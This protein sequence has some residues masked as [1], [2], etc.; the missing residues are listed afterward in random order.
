MSETTVALALGLLAVADQVQQRIARRGGVEVQHQ[1]VLVG[2]DGAQ[3]ELLRQHRLLQVDHQPHH[4]WL[5]LADPQPGDEGV[6]STHLADQFAQRRAEFQ[7]VDLDHQPVMGGQ[8]SRRQAARPVGIVDFV[9]H[10]REVGPRG[11][12]LID[13][14]QGKLE[15]GV[16]GVRAIA[17]RQVERIA[18]LAPDGLILYDLQDETARTGAE[19]PFPFL[20]TSSVMRNGPRAA[21]NG[22]RW[23]A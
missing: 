9:V 6:V 23:R 17:Q 10:V 1:A 12:D 21:M 4:P 18:G 8:D 19:R 2:G 7:R 13:P 20:P 14:G 5:V 11:A 3:R 22:I 15:M 16:A